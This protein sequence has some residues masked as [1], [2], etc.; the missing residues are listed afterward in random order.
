[1]A[2][3]PLQAYSTLGPV[4]LADVGNYSGNR[5]SETVREEWLGLIASE[6]DQTG[7]FGADI[8]PVAFSSGR[9]GIQ[10]STLIRGSAT[11]NPDA[12]EL[13]LFGNA[14]RTGLPGDFDLAGSSMNGFAVS[15]V[16]VSLAHA[17]E[18]VFLT[19]DLLEENLSVGA[20]FKFSLGHAMLLGQD[21]GTL[22]N[23]DPLEL[24]VSF[25]VIQ[26]DS[27]DVR[28][29]HGWGFGLDL[30][31]AW[32]G[33]PWS[34]GVVLKD[35]A[36]TFEWKVEDMFYRSGEAFYDGETSGSTWDPVSASQA[37]G[38]LQEA[39]TDLKFKPA[40]ALGG[41]Y[42]VSDAFQ[43]S[44]DI[45]KRFGE[46]IDVGPELH[47]GLGFEVKP[48]PLLAIQAGG[49]VITD[50]YQGGGGISLNLGP[51]QLG[52]AGM[53]QSGDLGDRS[54]GMVSLTFKGR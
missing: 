15:T 1:M 24:S 44:T 31:V 14:G 8:T 6:G 34:V 33:G 50:G 25:P 4:S 37:P 35:L 42:A 21:A 7:G 38:A 47:L 9:F 26:S 45:R 10:A 13:L 43:V 23:D 29:N 36:N 12:A 5:L 39:V 16:G 19:K 49:A 28:A 54:V 30:G 17:F 41:A 11:L 32:T 2:V 20:T 48:L 52:G 46:G 53:Y 40:I 3:F 51:V 22:L 27:T 18:D